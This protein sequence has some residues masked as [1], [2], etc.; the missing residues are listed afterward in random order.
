MRARV[1]KYVV[2]GF[3]ALVCL[4]SLVEAG[5]LASRSGLTV[6]FLDVGQGDA[7]FIEAP[8]KT[9]VLIDAGRGR[10]VLRELGQ[11]MPFWDKSLDM[12]IATHD[13]AD[14][15]GG[16]P[17][18]LDSFRVDQSVRSSVTASTTV[19]TAFTEGLEEEG[20]AGM[21]LLRGDRVKIS[22]EVSLEVLFPD[23]MIHEV[24]ANDASLVTR[25]SYGDTC[26]ILTG[27]APQAVEEYLVELDTGELD[28][29]VL[30]VGHHGSKTSTS[31]EFVRAVSPEYAIISYGCDNSYGHPHPEVMSVLQ[32]EGVRVV[33]TCEEGTITFRGDGKT[34][35]LSH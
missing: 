12:I 15:I 5:R 28:C 29:E 32:D 20:S 10:E 1:S 24:D 21:N 11:V 3:I 8:N 14:H 30:K 31:R 7:I 4:F 2:I 6:A 17:A 9:Q 13:D 16:F 33:S 19:A 18:V 35:R 26:F 25:L 23:R 27:D 34:L 22:P